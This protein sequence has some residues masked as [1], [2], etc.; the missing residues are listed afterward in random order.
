MDV[1]KDDE[2]IEELINEI[3][4]QHDTVDVNISEESEHEKKAI[5]DTVVKVDNVSVRFNIASERID[6]LKEYFIK[7]IRKE[8]MFKEFFALKDVS[9]EI[10][11][12]EA[13]GFIGVN[14]SGKSTLLKLICGILKPY[15]GKV[16]VSG[17]I[18]PL[19]E[20]GAGFDY[21]LTA[22]ENIYLNGAVLGYDEK[23]MKEHFDEIVEFAELQNFLD[24]PIKNYSSGMA[25]R[26]GFAIA[27]MV[28]S[29]ILICDEVLA[30]GDY[31]FQLKC[32]KRMKELLDGGTT[33]LYVSHA[34]DS[35]KRLCDHALWLNKGRVVMKGGAIDVCDAYIKD[36]IGEI[37]AK[38]EGENVDY[39]IIQAG[40]KGTRLEHLTRNKPK[41]IVPVNNLPIVFHM[42]KK[43]P[44]KKYII[45]GDYKNEVLEKYLEAFGGTTCIS[46]KAQGQGTSAGLHQALEHIPAG[47]RF[48]LVWSDLILGEEVNIDETRGNVIGI[49]RDFECRWSYKDGQFFEEPSTEHGVAGLF[50]FSDKEIL[51]QA[52]QSGEFVRWL[53]SQNIDFA[54]MSLLDT[55]ETGTLEAIRRLSGH[56]GEYRCRPFNSIEVHDNILIKRPIDDQGKALAVNEVKWYSE[57]KKYNFDQIPIIYELNPLTMEKINGQNIYKAELDNEQKKTVID[58]LISSLEK[59]HGFAKTEADP[60][61]IMDTYFY[62]TFTR[63]DK[64][65]NLVPFALEKTI[66]INGK[67]YKNPF[68]YREKIKED[69]RNQCLYTC[70]SFSLIH[71]DCTF[72]N[73]MVDDKLNVIFLDPRGYFGSTELYGDV[74][75]DWAKLYYSID[76][77]Y[78]QFNNKNFELYIEEN[79]VRLDIATNGWKELAPYYLSQLKGVDAQ[80]IKFLHALIWLSLTTYAWE[81]YDSIC[82]AFYKGVM[83]MD[84]C[85][86][87]N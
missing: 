72:S 57:V 55:V 4:D 23:F 54:E 52:P 45:I 41:G 61:S 20:L 36:Q 60:Y 11:R 56:E 31:A 5:E 68:F 25:A 16:T 24:M 59:L 7:L 78:D 53:Q 44:D 3:N 64:I 30:V 37:K 19:I 14:G 86:K 48:M 6:N 58:N 67:D 34:T 9:L 63:L 12:G 17:S 22:R 40:G 74:D 1:R 83:L 33:L 13:W 87:D 77:D 29:D 2:I 27:T 49:S 84:E 15:K 51:A 73:T 75:Y 76:G 66:N 28:K 69:V 26:L 80:K 43:Y 8:L 46:V 81:D 50:I 21:D 70:K 79:G 47:K 39:I 71:G 42:F 18:A 85:L 32:E 35:V 38:V 82:G 65:R 10:K 62:K